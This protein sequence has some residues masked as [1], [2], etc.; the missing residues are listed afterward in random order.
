MP[1]KTLIASTLAAGLACLSNAADLS[2]A[3]VWKEAELRPHTTVEEAP[4]SI[5][6]AIN[7][8]VYDVSDSPKF[9]G[10]G[11]PYHHFTGRDASRAWVTECWDDED[12]LTWRMDGIEEM[13]MPRYLD[14]MMD[15]LASGEEIA[16]MDSL[17]KMGVGKE[18]LVSMAKITAQKFGG[19]SKKKRAQRREEDAVEA[20]QKADD[21]L[22]HWVGFFEGKYPVVGTVEYDESRPAPP[23]IC[24]KAM[25]KRPMKQGKLEGLMGGL[26]N[27]MGSKQGEGK[28][29]MP[30][31]VK[32]KLK[33]KAA[34]AADDGEERDEL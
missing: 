22:K 34:S 10:P 3:K 4:N 24:D 15:D 8:T 2:S 27:I 32:E 16:G 25:G 31:F 6:I 29:E 12:Q 23:P 13:F 21:G 20:K 17:D 14:E 19:V 28:E 5:L 11:G 9:Y 18:Q 30:D 1:S 7:R 33:Q 26:N